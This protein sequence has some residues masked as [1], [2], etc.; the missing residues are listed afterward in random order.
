MNPNFPQ[1]RRQIH[2]VDHTLQKWLLVAMVILETLLTGYAIWGLYGVLGDIVDD[3]LY[4]IHQS[5]EN[6]M[7]S[8]FIIEGAKV[9]IATGV[10]NLSALII[11]DRIWAVYVHKIVDGLDKIMLAA[12]RL[13]LLPKAGVKRLHA[14]LDQALRWQRTESLRLRRIRYSVRNLPDRLPDSD[15]ERAAAA[16]HLKII[17][18]RGNQPLGE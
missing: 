3:N 14:V 11:A 8:R 1:D 6:E 15:E 18:A 13:D 9:L 7:L 12:Q 17:E 10:V 16:A 2:Y 5:D 4:R